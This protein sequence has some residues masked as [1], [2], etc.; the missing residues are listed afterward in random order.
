MRNI[1]SNLKDK[2]ILLIFLPPGLGEDILVQYLKAGARVVVVGKENGR[3][4]GLSRICEAESSRCRVI[5]FGGKANQFWE[6]LE[7]SIKEEI[8]S[9]SIIYNFI[10]TL[11][12]KIKVRGELQ[13]WRL[14][15]NPE[16]RNRIELVD[17][18]LSNLQPGHRCLWFNIVY[19]KGGHKDGK[20]VFC[21][22]RYGVTGLSTAIETN[23]ALSGIKVINICLTY[24]KEHPEEFAVTHCN[25][26]VS[27]KFRGEIDEIKDRDA[28]AGF[29]VNK[30]SKLLNEIAGK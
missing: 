9:A 2:N 16:S 5:E 22:T 12:L 1:V 6:G 17:T 14:D 13:D 29:L 25:H 11:F 26:C 21:N 15:L 19:G 30:S 7:V 20:E 10:G 8:S 4:E 28:T 24:M 27:E 18:I 3:L 23:P